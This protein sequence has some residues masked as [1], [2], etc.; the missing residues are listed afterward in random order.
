MTSDELVDP[1]NQRKETREF[2]RKNETL[3]FGRIM[4]DGV[5]SSV[6]EFLEGGLRNEIRDEW[7]ESNLEE[8]TSQLRA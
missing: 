3:I 1:S 4:V 6:R 2:I 7:R 8:G 5:E